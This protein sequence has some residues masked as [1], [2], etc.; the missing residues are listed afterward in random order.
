MKK[1]HYWNFFKNPVTNSQVKK[2]PTFVLGF[3]KSNKQVQAV[4]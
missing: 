2:M 1:T 4:I 3:K